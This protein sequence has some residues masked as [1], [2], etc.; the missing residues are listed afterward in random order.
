[1]PGLKLATGLGMMVLTIIIHS[2]F[3]VG[4]AKVAK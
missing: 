3:M 4:G 2:L 1:M